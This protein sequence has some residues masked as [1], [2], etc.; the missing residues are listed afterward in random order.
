M[1]GDLLRRAL[2][3]Q[4]ELTPELCVEDAEL[5]IEAEADA[6]GGASLRSEIGEARGVVD[7][8]ARDQP[9]AGRHPCN[10]A[11]GSHPPFAR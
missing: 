7:A 10:R 5:A 6:M 1:R 3:E 9:D 11:S 2:A 8:V 4:M